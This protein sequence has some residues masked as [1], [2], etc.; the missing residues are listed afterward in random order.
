MS[1]Y[2]INT[3]DSEVLK[4]YIEETLEAALN[5]GQRFSVSPGISVGEYRYGEFKDEDSSFSSDK[6]VL[7]TVV[8]LIL[9]DLNA[10]IDN[11][12][13]VKDLHISDD[14]LFGFAYDSSDESK[15]L[16]NTN[17]IYVEFIKEGTTPSDNIISC[18][19]EGDAEHDVINKTVEYIYSIDWTKPDLYKITVTRINTV[20][21]ISADNRWVIND[22]KTDIIASPETSINSNVI[23]LKSDAS[24]CTAIDAKYSALD[25]MQ[26]ITSNGI[27]LPDI[28]NAEGL[29]ESE[30]KLFDEAL[31]IVFINANDD[32]HK[33][34]KPVLFIRKDDEYVPLTNKIV[35]GSTDDDKD[36]PFDISDLID[37]ESIVS[38]AISNAT[39]LE[40]DSKLFS[41]LVFDN[42]HKDEKNTENG[43]GKTVYPVLANVMGNEESDSMYNFKLY[44]A[45]DVTIDPAEGITAVSNTN[46][47]N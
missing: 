1:I 9:A 19:C 45:D 41:H 12:G 6:G 34:V 39:H 43:T 4:G 15:I 11:G 13:S 44:Y 38:K 27:K 42:A 2:D 36:E 10:D 16:Y 25:D 18:I 30:R 40:C 33:D 29:D 20:P 35:K 23:L 24:R 28:T 14:I 7:S 3:I 46:E 47:T 31:Y 22:K 37:I 5:L 26:E 32:I 21:Y 17:N 8:N